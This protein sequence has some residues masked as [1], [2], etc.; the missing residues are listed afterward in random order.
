MESPGNVHEAVLIQEDRIKAVGSYGDLCRQAKGDVDMWDLKGAAVFPGLIDGHTHFLQFSLRETQVDLSDCY[1][2]DS[3]LEKIKEGLKNRT[4]KWLLG[5]G[6]DKNQWKEGWPDRQQLDSITADVPAALSSKDGHSLWANSKALELAGIDASCSDPPGGKIER[7]DNGNP[8]GILKEKACELVFNK[9]PPP[10]IDECLEAL[11]QG[12][13]KAVSYGLTGVHSFEGKSS[14]RGLCDLH[15]QGQLLIR[16]FCG[17]P[18][19]SL[20]FVQEIGLTSGFGDSFLRIGPIKIFLDGALGSQT[21]AMLEPYYQQLNELEKGILIKDPGEFYSLAGSVVDAGFPLAIHAIGDG[22]NRIALNGLAKIKE[23]TKTENL[24]HRIE[25]AQLVAPDDIKSF[26][27]LNVIP[28]MQTVHLKVDQEL[29]DNY[30]GEERGRYAFACKSMIEEGSELVLGSD[31]PIETIDPLQGIKYAVFRMGKNMQEAL[32]VYEAVRGYTW[33][34][35]YA[36]GEETG[37]GTIAP[38]KL[39][40]LSIF[41]PDFMASPNLIDE[42]KAIGTIVNGKIVFRC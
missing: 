17:I 19:D 37:K 10:A 33:G 42:A 16:F 18:E 23:Q 39:A 8:S 29:I 15:K 26:A 2:L 5:G 24:R 36:A 30:W 9:V 3:A 4:G 12:M 31:A 28:S 27:I 32:T 40:D 41:F 7:E 21:A 13:R 14:L 1:T 25:H 11:K 20:K 38:G 34:P 35:V 22:A 6:W